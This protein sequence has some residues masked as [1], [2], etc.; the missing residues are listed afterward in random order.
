MFVLAMQMIRLRWR[1]FL[2]AFATVAAAVAVVTAAGI[3]LESG[4]RA[5]VPPERLRGATLVVHADQTIHGSDDE[6][7]AM[8]ERV[9][10]PTTSVDTIGALPGVASAVGDV[11]F[12]AKLQRESGR[13][14]RGDAPMFGHRWSSAELT[15]FRLA[16]GSPPI[17]PHDVVVDRSLAMHVRLGVGDV[18]RVAAGG[19]TFRAR[20]VG[21]NEPVEARPLRRQ[22]ALFFTDATADTLALHPGAVDLIGVQLER[23]ADAE[24]VARAIRAS[25][26]S[27]VAVLSGDDRGRA[28][29]VDAAESN[30]RLI[31]I[32]GSLGGIAIAVAI[33]VIA[34]TLTLVVQQ[35]SRDIALLRAIAATPRQIRRLI[36]FETFLVTVAATAV[37]LWPGI[38]L[39]SRLIGGMQDQGL[40]PPTFRT[41]AGLLPLVIAAGSAVVVAQV[42]A[43]IAG[44]RAS[45]VSPTAAL[46]ALTFQSPRLGWI[47]GSLG[48][49]ALCGA[50]VVFAVAQSTT[51]GVATAIAPGLVMLFMTAVGLLAPRLVAAAVGVLAIPFRAVGVSGFL[52]GE[53]TRS[54]ARRLASAITPLVLLVGIAGMTVFQQTTLS[55]EADAQ[56][57]Q[58]I[59]ADRVVAANGSGI[60]ARDVATLGRAAGVRA[61][62][63]LAPTDIYPVDDLT[64]H[65][66][67]AVTE[68]RIDLV[69]HLEVRRGQ[70]TVL[71]PGEIAVSEA[72]ARGLGVTVGDVAHVR[73]G[74]GSR[75]TAR[76]VAVYDRSL[77]FA[78]ALLPWADVEAHL[79]EPLA[80]MVLIREDG[81]AITHALRDFSRAHPGTSVGGPE[82]VQAAEDAN[83]Q[84]NAWIGYTLLGL[85]VV[86]VAIAVINTLVMVTTERR[87]EF[88]LLR[89]VGATPRQVRRMV[90]WETLIIVMIGTLLG[91]GVAAGTVL[92]FSK[93]VTGSFRPSTPLA[94]CAAIVGGTFLIGFAAT[95]L[96]LGSAL[97]QHPID[98]L[99]VRD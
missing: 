70:L 29:F 71:H 52:A 24:A 3:M 37:G 47:R 48:I 94:V 45:R 22:R 74:D 57:S 79:T 49:L 14:V 10:L 31:A 5:D 92:P 81:S 84:A 32:S 40:L 98:A 83:A 42:A 4:I 13:A 17:E 95:L 56:R 11:S 67:Q 88:G 61:A 82:L 39:A 27:G 53:N 8:L 44:R 30:T 41:Q 78:D 69:L 89:L 46:S 90:R 97:R 51:V 6:S 25:V 50:G 64:M 86:F 72:G 18:V 65:P 99:D 58:R 91:V 9:R 77:G 63:G 60:D 28:E 7:V 76:V 23:R 35:H 80:A 36:G 34:G 55:T 54:Y 1:S 43:R 20:I 21:I 33:F 96:P 93:V 26:G 16:A 19:T 66:A 15:P 68:G 73:L 12:A 85:I 59:V 87:R 62:V 75:T 38:W 2:G